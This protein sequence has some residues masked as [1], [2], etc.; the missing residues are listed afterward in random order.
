VVGFGE[1]GCPH[2]EGTRRLPKYPSFSGSGR[3]G[4]KR[5]LEGPGTR[6]LSLQTTP[7]TLTAQVLSMRRCSA[8]TRGSALTIQL[9]GEKR[10]PLTP[11][12]TRGRLEATTGFE[13]VDGGFADLCLTT[14]LRRRAADF[15]I[16]IRR[17]QKSNYALDSAAG[18]CY[19]DCRSR[20][21]VRIVSK[22]PTS[23]PMWGFVSPAITMAWCIMGGQS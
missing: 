15:S 10:E 1:A 5:I 2:P 12:G 16:L 7:K 23:M 3:A 18:P 8:M 11:P 14:W 6:R 19:D 17:C 20:I 22:R 21:F 13:P 4:K 9:E